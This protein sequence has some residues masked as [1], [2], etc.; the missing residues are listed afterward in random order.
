MSLISGPELEKIVNSA[1]LW[2]A[3]IRLGLI[4]ALEED[5]PYGTHKLSQTEQLINFEQ[6]GPNEMS[7]MIA[8]LY[9]RY[10]GLP[11]A[12]ERVNRDLAAY[13]ARMLRL[14]YYAEPVQ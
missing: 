1:A 10:R 11:D 13:I 5:H 14:R 8:Q 4:Q 3:N 6:M 9:D 12:Q 2:Y 7:Q